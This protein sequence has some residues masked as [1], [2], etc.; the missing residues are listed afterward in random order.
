MSSYS[1]GQYA[2]WGRVKLLISPFSPDSR[3]VVGVCRDTV[4]YGYGPCLPDIL[5]MSAVKVPDSTTTPTLDISFLPA[6][7]CI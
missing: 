7:T 6:T 4:Q 3:R 5:P 2:V 1:A